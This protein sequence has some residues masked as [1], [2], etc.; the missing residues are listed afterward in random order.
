MVT[1][2][3]ASTP[4]PCSDWRMRFPRYMPR[5]TRSPSSWV[6]ANLP[7]P[8]EQPRDGPPNADYM[9][10]LATMINALAFRDAMEHAG[11]PTRVQTAISIA[12]VAEPCIRLRAIRHLEKGRVVSSPAV[13][14]IRSSPPTLRPHCPP[15]RLVLMP[16]S[17]PP[18]WTAFTTPTPNPSQGETAY[19]AHIHAGPRAGSSGDGHTAITM[20]MDNNL[21]IRVFNI[22]VPGNIARAVRGDG[23]HAGSLRRATR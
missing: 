6:A 23:G 10:M 3:M 18:G 20:C 4:R 21:P 16:C 12:Q 17:R 13:P 1:S 11:V 19:R 14:A 9:G 22:S 15:P 5:A 2:A 7:R 8:L